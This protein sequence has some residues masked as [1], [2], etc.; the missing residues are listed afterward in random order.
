MVRA[1]AGRRTMGRWAVLEG[2]SA[3]VILIFHPLMGD[4]TGSRSPF[5]HWRPRQ[6]V[7]EIPPLLNLM[8][9]IVVP[10][11]SLSKTAFPCEPNRKSPPAQ[12]AVARIHTMAWRNPTLTT[13]LPN[14]LVR[15]GERKERGASFAGHEVQ[16]CK[17]RC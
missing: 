2:Y 11:D 4:Q 3:R 9:P 15:P 6:L 13:L 1:F 5:H 10:L 17:D 16:K 8:S 14:C 12:Y 7:S